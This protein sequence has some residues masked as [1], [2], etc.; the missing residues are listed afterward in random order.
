MYQRTYPSF[1]VD[2]QHDPHKTLY[3]EYA[4]GWKSTVLG[5]WTRFST[6]A[7]CRNSPGP[8]GVLSHSV[9]MSQSSLLVLL[10]E[11]LAILEFKA[12]FIDFFLEGTGTSFKTQH[13]KNS[14]HLRALWMICL[15]AVA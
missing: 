6:S 3:N 9:W 13:P 11:I 7:M 8:E 1:S 10:P 15:Y 12:A 14:H 5:S 2:A 4:C